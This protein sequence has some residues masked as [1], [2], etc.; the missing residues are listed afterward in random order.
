[1]EGELVQA[2]QS[3]PVGA[4]PDGLHVLVVGAGGPLPDPDRTPTCLMVIAGEEV[5]LFDVGGGAAREM[6]LHGFAPGLVDRVFLTHY[7]S[8][9]VDG[10][11]EVATQRWAGASWETRLPVHGPEEVDRVVAGF[12]EAYAQ[13]QRYRQAHHGP[14]VTP[15]KGAGLVAEA[16]PLPAQG[17]APVVWEQ[18]DVRVRA[19]A[20]NHEPVVPAVGYR[21]DYKGRSIA[22]SGDTAKSENLI[23]R[24]QGVDVLFHDALSRE[25]VKVMN[26][27]ARKAGQPNLAKITADIPDY[28]ASPVE[29]AESAAAAGAGALVVYHV[30]PPLPLG[31]L[32]RV[33]EEGMDEAFDGPIE[34]SVNGTFVSLPAGS[35]ALEIDSP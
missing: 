26:S 19:F 7:H 4:L 33:F 13:D 24:S 28:H 14:T 34:V 3:D 22:I 20:V 11:G 9:H 12:N 15:P 32:R 8:D 2:M 6:Q 27:A 25:L 35:D 10:L 30:V 18:G 29:A 16:F 5:M 23:Q 21:V 31:A 17:E 1:M